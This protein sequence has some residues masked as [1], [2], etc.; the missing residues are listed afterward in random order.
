MSSLITNYNRCMRECE[1]SV[2]SFLKT[3]K[4]E[5]TFR[6]L[7]NPFDLELKIL[8][9]KTKNISILLVK[10][11]QN[12]SESSFQNFNKRRFDIFFFQQNQTQKILKDLQK[13][14]FRKK[15]IVCSYS[16]FDKL[17]RNI[18]SLVETKKINFILCDE[19]HL[20]NERVDFLLQNSFK[21][22]KKMYFSNTPTTEQTQHLCFQYNELTHLEY[23]TIDVPDDGNCFFH[24]LSHFLKKPHEQIRKECIDYF[25]KQEELIKTYGLQKKQIKHLYRD[26]VWNTNEFD[27]LPRIASSLYNR[28]IYLY[29]EDSQFLETFFQKTFHDTIYLSLKNYHYNIV[30]YPKISEVDLVSQYCKHLLDTETLEEDLISILPLRVLSKHKNRLEKE[31]QEII[32]VFMKK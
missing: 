3:T 24:C 19:S 29:K 12:I 15:I 26:G 22:T 17:T 2:S 21:T 18:L 30:V 1:E 8:L 6:M 16:S 7:F 13:N 31:E 25:L 14:P 5:G 23:E 11:F 4:T 9:N 20:S 27:I 32:N 10:C 28:T